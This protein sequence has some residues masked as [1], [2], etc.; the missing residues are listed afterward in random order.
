[1]GA[2]TTQYVMFGSGS[3]LVWQAVIDHH[4]WLNGS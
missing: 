2:D 4:H 1:M 3:R